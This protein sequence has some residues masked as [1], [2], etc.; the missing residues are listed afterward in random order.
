MGRP[1]VHRPWADEPDS[2]LLEGSFAPNG[3]GAVDQSTIK[4]AWIS[5]V[6]RDNAGELTLTMVDA[7]AR[8]EYVEAHLQM[9]AA[10]DSCA[11]VGAVD[12]TAK[13]IKLHTLTAGAAADIAANANN[14][15]NVKLKVINTGWTPL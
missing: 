12:L 6:A 7:F 3:A 10:T 15:V 9:A 4:G 8:Y 5:S 2:V 1:D 13:T 14:R 11:Q